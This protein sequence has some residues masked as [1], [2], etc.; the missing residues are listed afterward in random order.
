VGSSLVVSERVDD[1]VVLLTLNRP[2]RKNALSIAL[3]DEMSDELDRIAP[4]DDVRAVVITGAGDTFSSGFDLGELGSDD[5]AVRDRLWPSS[6]RFHHTVLRF[7]L[8]TIA[9]VNGRALAG[10]F[11]LAVLC[12][13]RIAAASASF[14]HPERAFGDVV[15][16]PLHDLVGGAAA[17]DLCFTGRA[18]D[19]HEAFRLGLVTRVVPDGELRAS[20]TAMALEVARAPREVLVRTKAKVLARLAVAPD[21]TTLD[22]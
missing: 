18:V 5:P 1:G 15:Y 20:A 13:L 22:L 14:A 7:P 9:A 8:P 12:D 6:D 3:R 4:D 17:R 21:T 19:A 10:G 16:A 11:D 2:D